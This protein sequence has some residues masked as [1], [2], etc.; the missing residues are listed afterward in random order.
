MV[1][2]K[3]FGKEDPGSVVDHV[4][5]V[6]VRNVVWVIDSQLVRKIVEPGFQF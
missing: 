6:D 5:G 2:E 3:W 4:E 1:C